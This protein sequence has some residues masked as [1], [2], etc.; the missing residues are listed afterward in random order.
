MHSLSKRV[1]EHSSFSARKGEEKVTITDF[2][3]LNR[4]Y[5]ETS[6]IAT[7]YI[8]TS[9]TDTGLSIRIVCT[10]RQSPFA[11]IILLSGLSQDQANSPLP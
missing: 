6:Y 9:H 1:T 2:C 8:E 10:L 7:S 11:A 3:M 5:I 4:I